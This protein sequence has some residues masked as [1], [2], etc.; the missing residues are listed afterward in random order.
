M[1]DRFILKSFWANEA[2]CVSVAYIKA[3]LI[4]HGLTGGYRVLKSKKYIKVRLRDGEILSFLPKEI[5][6]IN[7]RNTISFR[8]Y[9]QPHDNKRCKRLKSAVSL[10]FAILVKNVQLKEYEDRQLTKQDAIGLLTKKGV[11]TRSFHT[12]LG[13]DRTPARKLTV[14]SFSKLKKK[15]GILIYNPKHIVACSSGY[16]DDYGNAIALANEIPLLLEKKATA[17]FELK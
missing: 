8:R 17:W 2:N 13:V 16:Y 4:K 14:K 6:E 7:T 5:S 11:T 3:F 1:K 15:K 10:L 9:K 12:L